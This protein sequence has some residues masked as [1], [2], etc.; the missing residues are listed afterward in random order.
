[1]RSAW[2]GHVHLLRALLQRQWR[3]RYATAGLGGVWAVLQPL[4]QLALY[5]LVFQWVFQVRLPAGHDGQPYIVWLALG[6]WPWVALQDCL[7]RG[8]GAIVAQ[9]ALVQKVAFAHGLLVVAAVGLPWAVHG[10]GHLLVLAV[11]LA[12][13]VPLQPALIGQWP[14]TWLL[15]GALALGAAFW[16][17]AVQV[18]VR[19]VEQLL[20]QLLPLLMYV[21]PV[22][23]PLALVPASLQAVVACNPLT[24][25][26]EPL[27]AAGL[28]GDPGWS[29]TQAVLAVCLGGG[30][31]ALGAWGF[32]RLSHD[33]EDAL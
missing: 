15:L 14:L 19:D 23:Y 21:S 20:P 12:A 22:L 2:W 32:A 5:A 30:W 1:M 28:G 27:R 10:L 16:L 7:V 8:A 9:A 17:A 4:A 25:L 3:E 26:L 31:V 29:L 13:G 11:L 18:Y 33:F 24:W 6:L